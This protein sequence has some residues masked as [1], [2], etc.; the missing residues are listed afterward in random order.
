[1]VIEFLTAL[2][3][4]FATIGFHKVPVTERKHL[5]LGSESE[6]IEMG[7]KAFEELKSKNELSEN[8]EHTNTL[9]RCGEAIKAVAGRDDFKWEFVLFDSP[10]ENAYCLPG[11]KVAFFSSLVD[12]MNN[13]A[14]MAFV[15]AHEIAHAIARHGGERISWRRIQSLGGRILK[16]KFTN[17]TVSVVYDVGSE[18]GLMLPFSRKNEAE[19]D[20][21]GLMLMAKAGYDPHAAVEFW[22]RLSA[23]QES[24][25][26]GNLM[27][28]HP[29]DEKRIAAMEKNLPAAMEEYNKAADKKGYGVV[30]FHE[31]PLM[32]PIVAVTVAG[33]IVILLAVCVGRM[34]HQGPREDPR[35]NP[36][37]DK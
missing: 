20:K 19:A 4:V 15:M 6:E 13:E 22:K 7:E 24:S 1:M 11:G 12:R 3:L 23:G 34:L 10:I 33:S 30:F 8:V 32:R 2:P 16:S 35:A 18:L 26:V 9:Q 25:V 5:I 14:E 28:T 21:I 27:S 17:D 29:C 37:P 36:A 31:A